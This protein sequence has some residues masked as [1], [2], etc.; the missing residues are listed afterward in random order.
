MAGTTFANLTRAAS[1]AL[2][3]R[4][5]SLHRLQQRVSERTRKY[6][7]TGRRAREVNKKNRLRDRFWADWGLKIGFCV[8]NC[9][10]ASFQIGFSSFFENRLFLNL[11]FG[12]F[13]TFERY[14]EAWEHQNRTQHQKI[15]L[16]SYPENFSLGGRPVSYTHLTLPTKA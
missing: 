3:R 9:I 6:P 15:P 5:Y 10:G 16:G 14:F 8:K 7:P 4:V 13:F 12:H 11:V 2:M 1:A